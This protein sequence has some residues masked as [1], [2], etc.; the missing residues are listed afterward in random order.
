MI[1]P[2]GKNQALRLYDLG[3]VGIIRLRVRPAINQIA[4]KYLTEMGCSS[5]PR[6]FIARFDRPDP[7]LREMKSKEGLEK[8]ID[9]LFQSK[10][11]KSDPQALY[12]QPVDP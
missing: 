11:D 10:E 5:R 9:Q 1:Y 6:P 2:V 7:D 8:V 12:I 4:V 3:A